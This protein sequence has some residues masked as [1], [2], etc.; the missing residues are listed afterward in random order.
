MSW[1]VR[2]SGN[3]E[4]LELL[5]NKYSGPDLTIEYRE[6]NYWLRSVAFDLDITWQ[7]IYEKGE[8]LIVFLNSVLN[9]YTLRTGEIQSKG[10]FHL[11]TKGNIENKF[12]GVYGSREI[13][14]IRLV[15]IS[16]DLPDEN[17]FDLFT[18]H[19]NV[20]Y[21]LEMLS[22]K[23]LDWYSL[24]SV[25]ETIASDPEVLKCFRSFDQALKD[26][27]K[28]SEKGRFLG[29]AGWH[30]HSQ[31]GS[32]KG[33]VNRPPKTPMKLVEAENFVRG[34]TIEWLSFKA[35]KA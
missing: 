16:D 9:L 4:A 25:Y 26:W 2:L 17:I 24:F 13:L 30:R 10:Y 27:N 18:S 14:S 23:Q 28:F 35:S 33:K 15:T 29:T 1:L 20:R 34:L 22:Q 12:I 7:E 21:V 3:E 5:R 8:E 32:T 11:D 19:S 6:G 31:F